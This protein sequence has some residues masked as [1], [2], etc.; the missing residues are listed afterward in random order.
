VNPDLP[1]LAVFRT[2]LTADALAPAS[3]GD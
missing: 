3:T 2:D 1:P